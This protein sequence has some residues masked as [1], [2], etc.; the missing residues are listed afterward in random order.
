MKKLM[1][2]LSLMMSLNLLAIEIEGKKIRN[3]EVLTEH[4]EVLRNSECF[5]TYLS[6]VL[7]ASSLD[8]V[9]MQAPNVTE[10]TISQEGEVDYKLLQVSCTSGVYNMSTDYFVSRFNEE[11][12]QLSFVSMHKVFTLEEKRVLTATTANTLGYSEIKNVDGKVYITSYYKGRGLGDL[13][14]QSSH[15]LDSSGQPQF[16]RSVNSDFEND[17]ADDKYIVTVIKN[18][19]E[20]ISSSDH[21]VTGMEEVFVFVESLDR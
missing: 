4:S 1:T 21:S 7:A 18:N 9:F 19:G 6:D 3:D 5:S 16:V 13:F 11:Y 17:G 15:V 8:D 20:Q 2:I 12:K 10:Y 14:Y